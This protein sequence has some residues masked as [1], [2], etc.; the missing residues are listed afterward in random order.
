[1]HPGYEQQHET[2]RTGRPEDAAN[3]QTPARRFFF[4]SHAGSSLY[5]CLFLYV[6][7]IDLD[8][9]G[10]S[11]KVSY[12][13]TWRSLFCYI[14]HAARSGGRDISL[15]AHTTVHAV[16]HTA[17]QS[18]KVSKSPHIRGISIHSASA[19]K[20]IG[21][22]RPVTRRESIETQPIPGYIDTSGL[23]LEEQ[24]PRRSRDKTRKYRN[25]AIHELY[26]YI[27]PLY[28]R[29]AAPGGP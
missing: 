17:V 10:I 8:I 28:G 1:M 6:G 23:R 25:S 3:P 11:T 20:S 15:Y 14:I 26:R 13:N 7:N 22:G 16:R 19:M 4:C 9:S 21:P 2:D 12:D 24:R 18:E 5:S 29:A 27:R